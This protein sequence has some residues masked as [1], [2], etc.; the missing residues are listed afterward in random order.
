MVEVP[1]LA[2]DEKGEFSLGG[3]ED[4]LAVDKMSYLVDDGGAIEVRL[5]LDGIPKFNLLPPM[6]WLRAPTIVI[7]LVGVAPLKN[8]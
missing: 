8:V 4:P 6:V 3:L 1:R 7:W 2:W 5:V